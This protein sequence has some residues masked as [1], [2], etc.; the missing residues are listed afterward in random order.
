MECGGFL[1]SLLLGVWSTTMLPPGCAS[2]SCAFLSDPHLLH[3]PPEVEATARAAEKGT[4]ARTTTLGGDA[5]ERVNCLEYGG[6]GH[7]WEERSGGSGVGHP[8][9]TMRGEAHLE[10]GRTNHGSARFIRR[11]PGPFPEQKPYHVEQ[12]V[13]C[14]QGFRRG[15]KTQR[16]SA[17]WPEDLRRLTAWSDG[18]ER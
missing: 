15:E 17:G 13:A 12:T 4:L 16:C 18:W 9:A 3:G 6:G 8:D 2:S 10:R 5:Q 7:G 11:R 14:V 1:S